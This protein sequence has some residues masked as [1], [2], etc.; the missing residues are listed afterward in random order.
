MIVAFV[1]LV[2]QKLAESKNWGHILKTENF[3]DIIGIADI[4]SILKKLIST[5]GT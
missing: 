2:F 5:P 4:T 1:S 3:A